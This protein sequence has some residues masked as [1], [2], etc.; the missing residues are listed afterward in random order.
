MKINNFTEF[1]DNLG[2][3]SYTLENAEKAVKRQA[4]IPYRV[5]ISYNE[6]VLSVSISSRDHTHKIKLSF[7]FEDESFWVSIEELE[8]IDI[9]D[10]EDVD[11]WLSLFDDGDDFD[12]AIPS[13]V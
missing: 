1:C 13:F 6:D 3:R 8:T 12:D 10:D 7:P 2:L 9:V 11:D 5:T 4:F